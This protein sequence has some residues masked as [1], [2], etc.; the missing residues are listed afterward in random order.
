M[1]NE[2]SNKISVSN[3][4][5]ISAASENNTMMNII[6]PNLMKSDEIDNDKKCFEIINDQIDEQ[7]NQETKKKRRIT[8]IKLD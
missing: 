3:T 2:N 6:D 8:P 4:N 5:T 7:K 1:S